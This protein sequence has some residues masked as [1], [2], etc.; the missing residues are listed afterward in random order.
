MAQCRGTWFPF[1][2]FNNMF[3]VLCVMGSDSPLVVWQDFSLSS[4]LGHLESPMKTTSES[5][6]GNN[7][8]TSIAS[9]V[10][11]PFVLSVNGCR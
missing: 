8:Q 4:F 2:H 3:L 6:Q 5:L 10:S 9:D 1:S 11:L 7:E